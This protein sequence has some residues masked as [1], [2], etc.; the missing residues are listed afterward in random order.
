MFYNMN[1]DNYNQF[2]TERI[3]KRGLSYYK[4]KRVLTAMKREDG[5]YQIAVRGDAQTYKVIVDIRKNGEIKDITCNC[6]YAGGNYYCKH[7][8]AALLHLSDIFESDILGGSSQYISRLITAYTKN[9]VGK[10]EDPITIEPEITFGRDYS[11]QNKKLSFKLKI[12]REKKYIVN[13]ISRLESD[14]NYQVNRAYGKN[15]EFVHN[16]NILDVRSRKLME[17]ASLIHSQ[18]G[19][20]YYSPK[21]FPLKDKFLERFLEIYDER[22]LTI[23]KKLFTVTESVPPVKLALKSIGNGNIKLKITAPV[24][25][26]GS[27]EYGYFLSEEQQTIYKTSGEYARTVEP[28][29]NELKN[30]QKIFIAKEDIPAFYNTVI[31]QLGEY[32]DIDMTEVDEDIIPVQLSVQLYVDV[33]QD[34]E[35]CASLKF[36]YGDKSYPSSYDKS[37]NPFIDSAG[38]ITALNTVKKYFSYDEQDRKTPFKIVNEDNIFDFISSGL[39]A[40]SKDMEVYVSNKFKR[41]NIRKSVKTNVG[42]RVTS[43]LLDIDISSSGY[44]TEELLELLNSCRKK[45]KYHRFKDGSFTVID[46]GIKELDTLTKELNITDKA[47]LKENISVPMYRMLYLNSMQNDCQNI[48]LKRSEE[49]KKLA[50]TYKNAL[51]DEN[52]YA[53]P[54]TLENVMRDYQKYG[55]RW[56]KTLST[57]RMG[58]ILADDMG[59]G[60]TIQAIS[61]MLSEKEKSSGNQKTQFLVIC[62][63]SLT[64]NWQNEIKRFAP[65][66]STVCLNGTVAERNKLFEN[67]SDYDVLITSYATILRDINKYENMHFAIQF[68]DEAQNIKNHNT[69]SAKAVKLINS[70]LKFALTGTPVENTLAELWSIFDFIMPGYLHHYGYFKKNYETPIVKQEDTYAIKSLQRLTSPFILRRLKKEVLTELPDKT[71]TVLFTEME[72]EQKKVYLAYAAKLKTELQSLDNQNDKIKILAMLTRLRQICCDPSLVYENYE[73]KSAKLEQCIELVKSCVES[74]HKILLFSQFTTMLD[75]ISERLTEEKIT[76]F[77]LTGQTKT[78]ERLNLVNSF[79][80]NDV[81]VFLISLKAG[82]TGLN[83]TGAD[84]VIHFDPWWNL[85]AENQASDRV[86]RIGQ[87]NNVQIYKLITKDTIEEKIRDLQIRKADIFATAVS[88]EGDIANMTTDEIIELF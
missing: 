43:G 69:Q 41:M 36:I 73:G 71:E 31:K 75:T 45:K 14:F 84:I 40:L 21:Q 81:N 62:P 58:G 66:L 63:S 2:F 20:D 30:V 6:P 53:L 32:M 77:T 29:I 42:V 56:L 50:N 19:Y 39:Q 86:Y 15:L 74:G 44:T 7:E 61:L 23:D 8:Y 47:F 57:Y 70:T 76:Y 33:N 65:S 13:D 55:F 48:R 83:L 1:I 17:L 80:E 87:K 25:Y 52:I 3:A 38:E 34:D 85:S 5:K 59:L 35:I 4:N 78:K 67:I 64:I 54:E 68:L 27:A 82:G 28:L 10:A 49:F 72:E 79:N 11:S 60:K 26:L 24:E 88:G 51:E 9:A 12:G 46:D 18:N 37:Q 22:P 16:Y